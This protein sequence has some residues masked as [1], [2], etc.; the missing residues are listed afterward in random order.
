MM[1]VRN[2]ID[3]EQ[4]REDVMSKRSASYFLKVLERAGG[5]SRPGGPDRLIGECGYRDDSDILRGQ[6]DQPEPA[7]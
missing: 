5:A 3:E 4:S 1:R 7:L 2:K 6:A